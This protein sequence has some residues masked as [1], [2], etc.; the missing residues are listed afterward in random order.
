MSKSKTN[1]KY[2]TESIHSKEKKALFKL[3]HNQKHIKME[4]K[5]I[6]N[7]SFKENIQTRNI[8]ALYEEKMVKTM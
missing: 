6:K 1:K 8:K 3:R 7:K 2:F 5:N 4:K